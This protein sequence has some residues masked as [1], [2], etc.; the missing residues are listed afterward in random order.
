[1]RSLT[2]FFI[3]AL[4]IVSCQ[5]KTKS[6]TKDILDNNPSIS[7]LNTLIGEYKEFGNN[8]NRFKIIKEEKQGFFYQA[9]IFGTDKPNAE[10]YKLEEISL[11]SLKNLI[12][13]NSELFSSIWKINNL[14]IGVVKPNLIFK[15]QAIY[16]SYKIDSNYAVIT[17]DGHYIKFTKN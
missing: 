11:A 14:Y 8:R 5:N 6:D 1:M 17:S 12:G 16:G 15:D 2:F 3:L 4:F 10:K 9:Y 7:D 13:N